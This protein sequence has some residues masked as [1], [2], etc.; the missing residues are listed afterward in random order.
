MD[1]AIPRVILKEHRWATAAGYSFLFVGIALASGLWIVSLPGIVIAT[2][3][4]VWSWAAQGR[5]WRTVLEHDRRVCTGCAY[6][7]PKDPATGVCPE[8]GGKYTLETVRKQ[9][10]DFGEESGRN[11]GVKLK[12]S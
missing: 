4:F 6:P 2:G 3:M 7:L 9:W 12:Q 8:C 5:I 11:V 10:W 1:K